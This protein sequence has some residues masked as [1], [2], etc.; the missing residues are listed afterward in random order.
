MELINAPKTEYL[1]DASLESLHAESREWLSDIDFWNE[2]MSFFYKLVHLRE[3][4]HLSFP[5]ADLAGLEK[6]LIR[7]AADLSEVKSAIEGH[8]R[9][10]RAVIQNTSLS[11]EQDYRERHRSLDMKVRRTHG[12]I[13]RFKKQVFAFI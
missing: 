8:E 10:L 4:H 13:R 6:E 1:L 3:P 2:E 7:I 5:S 12:L 11:E 9:T